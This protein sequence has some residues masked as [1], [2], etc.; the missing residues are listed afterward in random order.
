MKSPCLTTDAHAQLSQHLAQV[1][2]CTACPN[3][4]GPVVTHHCVVSKVYLVG[5]AP[6]PREASF[7]RPF[8]WTAGR[9]LFSWFESIGVN[10]HQFRSNAFMAAVCRCF[11]GKTRG[12]GD[13]V[14]NGDEIKACSRWIER[15]IEIMNPE[16]IIPVGRLAMEQFLE[17]APLTELVGKQFR[18][19]IHGA[20]R[21]VI[22]LPHSSGVSTWFKKE[23][24]KGLL[25]Q[26]LE[27]LGR[28]PRWK[29][30]QDSPQN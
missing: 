12:G 8:A 24:G 25:L 21:D 19:P 4:I 26:A 13:R 1:N 28:H 30:L 22:A 9:T 17:P 16:L 6:G 14:P 2:A 27:L 5:Q 29:E 23:P 7:G 18:L 20:D 15:E 11:P 3:M 10:E